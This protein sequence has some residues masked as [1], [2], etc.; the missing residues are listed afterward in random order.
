MDRLDDPARQP[1]EVQLFVSGD[2]GAH[3]NLYSKAPPTQQN[4][5]FRA[6]SDGEFWFA[7][8]TI[9]RAGQVRPET[10][11]TPGLRV[12]VDTRPQSPK[13]AWAAIRR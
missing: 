2:R 4:F 6:G 3:W 13:P 5:L 10:I 7:I 8:R 11:S 9:D 12:L 1:V